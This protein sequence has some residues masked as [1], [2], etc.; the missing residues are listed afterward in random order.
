M[1]V[2]VGGS[3]SGHT[4]G[5]SAAAAAG[6][7]HLQQ[8]RQGGEVDPEEE[9]VFLYKLVPGVVASSYGVS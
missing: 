9:H 8:E 4:G 5:T 3:G 6:G 1:Q 7:T 2:L